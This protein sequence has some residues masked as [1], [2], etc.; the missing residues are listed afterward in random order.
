MNLL[1]SRLLYHCV[2][3][4]FLSL[5]IP[6]QVN[7]Q[8]VF[9]EAGSEGG[10]GI[11]RARGDEC[12]LIAPLH[13]VEQAVGSVTIVGAN[14]TRSQA[15]VLR[16]GPGDIAIL[17][18]VDGARLSCDEWR[19][20][21]NFDDMLDAPGFLRT[22]EFGVTS[23]G[24]PI[25]ISELDS[26]YFFVRS[27]NSFKQIAMRMS[28]S[29]LYVNGALAGMLVTVVEDIDEQ[30]IGKVLQLDDIMRLTFEF[31]DT[32]SVAEKEQAPSIDVAAATAI[33]DRA[34]SAR[35]GSLQGQQEAVSALLTQGYEFTSVDWSGLNLQGA[36]L[37]RGNFRNA[38]MHMVDLT[39]VD[40]R[41]ADFSDTGLRFAKL[42]RSSMA[43]ANLSGSFAPFLNAEGATFDNAD[44]TRANLFGSDLR[45]VSFRNATLVGASLAFADLRGAVF[46]D[47]DLT[48]AHL[49]GAILD[50][51]STFNNA[52]ISNTNV[53]G[54][55]ASAVS[56][57]AG[58]MDGVCRYAIGGQPGQIGL[59][60][61]VDITEQWPDPTTATG[62]EFG[63]LLRA[64]FVLR[65]FGDK[66]LPACSPQGEL[67][68]GFSLSSLGDMDFRLMR[69]YLERANR[70]QYVIDRV[71]SH[72]ALLRDSLSPGAVL[73]GDGTELASWA[74]FIE[75][76]SK[77]LAP[78]SA[79]YLENEQALAVLLAS[80]VLSV[81]TI[82]GY[83]GWPRYAQARHSYENE[84]ARAGESLSNYS[85][86]NRFFPEGTPWVDLPENT[87][88]LY[89]QWVISRQQPN[90]L[91]IVSRAPLLHCEWCELPTG[92]I[93]LSAVFPGATF[94]QDYPYS[95][96]SSQLT[97]QLRDMGVERE[98]AAQFRTLDTTLV[99]VLP[100]KIDDFTLPIPGGTSMTRD[101]WLEVD[102][103]IDRIVGVENPITKRTDVAVLFLMPG[104]ARLRND[105]AT[106]WIGELHTN[107]EMTTRMSEAE[108]AALL[109]EFETQ[110]SESSESAG[111]AY[112]SRLNECTQF[113]LVERNPCTTEALSITKLITEMSQC[114][115]E[116]KATDKI[117]CVQGFQRQFDALSKK[118]A[119]DRQARLTQKTVTAEEALGAALDSSVANNETDAGSLLN[120]LAM[121]CY[122][123]AAGIESDRCQLII[124][125]RLSDCVLQGGIADTN[126]LRR[127]LLSE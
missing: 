27:D 38:R 89:R 31:F 114:G 124:N 93:P 100:A 87:P 101:S 76:A 96:W 20:S 83:S 47:A 33:L 125:R 21:T 23:I 102:F 107:A 106:T 85:A 84:I 12:F 74:E 122:S 73:V 40:A 82:D 103:E 127:C 69:S 45:G 99:L 7:G 10:Q 64:Q 75:D 112:K 8:V 56:L 88:D 55:A 22:L 49:A 14:E 62:Q 86:W 30:K 109:I 60:W 24:T 32:G 9:I 16:R 77:Q 120:N 15:Q 41:G 6:G 35:N 104:N 39:D 116:I 3:A 17:R 59:L 1:R 54:A 66:S 115:R 68:S 36:K 19:S 52:T 63:N 97:S 105:N 123:M 25:R 11:L 34:V 43:N 108:R 90:P 2:I 5:A 98:E 18:I 121:A 46:D 91:R 94:G 110:L 81:E 65:G 51:S 50:D 78:V 26:E 29:A 119:D 71:N 28:G 72:G 67:A 13:V 48:G 53:L 57:S 118:W 70:R 126:S 95:S 79:P 42:E 113:A 111:D 80:G 58:Q 61:D 117:E 44:F 37:N 4:V 92:D